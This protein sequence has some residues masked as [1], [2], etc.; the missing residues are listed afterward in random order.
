MAGRPRRLHSRGQYSIAVDSA[1]D[2]F[3]ADSSN[4]RVREINHATGVITT[5]A[6]NGTGGYNGNSQRPPPPNSRTPKASPWTPRAISS[7]PTGQQ[8]H[9]RGQSFHRPD[10][11]RRRYGRLASSATAGRPRRPISSP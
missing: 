11:H 10:H 5:V 6:G 4:N 8:P 3:I 9:P 1:G 7:S 2:I